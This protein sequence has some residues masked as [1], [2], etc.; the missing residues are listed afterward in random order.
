MSKVRIGFALFCC[1]PMLV[2]AAQAQTKQKPGLWEVT[3]QMTI[4]GMPQMPQMPQ[5]AQVPPGMQMPQSPFAPHTSQVCVTQAMIDKYGGPYQNPPRGDCQTTN[6][7]MKPDGMTA[8]ISC[9]GQMTAKGTVKATFTDS[10]S[11]STTVHIVGTMQMGPNNRP[12]DMTMQ[13]NGVYKGADC[14]TVKP[15]TMPAGN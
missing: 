6:L 12:V 3:S 11:Y 10:N 9:T 8:E 5:G 15:M 14:G 7:V 4:A 1:L 2:T 13:A